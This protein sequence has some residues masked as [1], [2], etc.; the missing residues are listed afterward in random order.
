VCVLTCCEI[1]V[2]VRI[3]FFFL[4]FMAE[5]IDTTSP[6]EKTILLI[7]DPQNDFHAG[8]IL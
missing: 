3:S 8:G 5:F 2:S 4:P 6:G 1:F 7:I